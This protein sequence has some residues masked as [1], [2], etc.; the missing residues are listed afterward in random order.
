MAKRLRVRLRDKVTF[1]GSVETENEYG[2]PEV[3]WSEYLTCSAE[4]MPLSASERVVSNQELSEAHYT[5]R[6]R[7]NSLTRSIDGQ[8][9]VIFDGHVLDVSPP[10]KMEGRNQYIEFR[11]VHRSSQQ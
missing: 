8:M 6:I 9:R 10:Q 4:V 11:A 5:I 1:E 3:T 7:S 2:E